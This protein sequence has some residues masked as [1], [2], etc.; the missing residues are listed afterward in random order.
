MK[1]SS[2][3]VDPTAA[4]EKRPNRKSTVKASVRLGSDAST[5]L[6][7]VAGALAAVLK[8]YDVRCACFTKPFAP[9]TFE[10]A[11]D[12]E[13]RDNTIVDTQG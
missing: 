11:N 4:Y 2:Y 3:T 9:L 12:C 8:H 10:Q 6:K 5:S 13:P 7:S 1:L